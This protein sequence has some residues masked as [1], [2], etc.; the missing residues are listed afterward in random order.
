MI[1]HTRS[2]VNNHAVAT[3]NQLKNY[4]INF[5]NMK[6]KC[7]SKPSWDLLVRP[8]VEVKFKNQS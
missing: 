6:K 8:K 4:Y 7:S 1:K 3:E 2:F 5:K